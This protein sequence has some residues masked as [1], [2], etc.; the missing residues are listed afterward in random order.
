MSDAKKKAKRLIAID[1]L[2]IDIANYNQ[3]AVSNPKFESY[4]LG[5]AEAAKS[6]MYALAGGES[7]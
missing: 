3:A 7:R 4:Y 2:S 5:K 6:K 1:E